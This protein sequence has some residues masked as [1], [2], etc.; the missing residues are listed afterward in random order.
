MGKIG[1]RL[2]R[3]AVLE[4]LFYPHRKHD[5]REAVSNLLVRSDEPAGT[6]QG[7]LCPHAS[8]QY[9]GLHQA[10]SFK[11]A[12]AREISCI[13]ILAAATHYAD[14]TPAIPE[15]HIFRTPLGDSLIDRKSL[16]RVKRSIPRLRIDDLPFLE[17]PAI[18]TPLPFIQFLWPH[19]RIVPIVVPGLA[20][21]EVEL[22]GDGL[23]EALSIVP[24]KHI[25]WIAS[26][27]IACG[28]NASQTRQ[29]AEDVLQL[30][31]SET[32]FDPVPVQNGVSKPR[33]YPAETLCRLLRYCIGPARSCEVLT[34]GSSCDLDGN[35]DSNTEY[36]AVAFGADSHSG[37]L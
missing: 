28:G 12:A 13:V 3:E 37:V 33:T 10:T 36:A 34:R 15:S 32:H 16:T 19:A 17:S 8:L 35:V 6:A 25:L 24:E 5:L 22:L 14:R 23:R 7:I 4:G 2:V 20:L 30:L 11:A 18:E 27:N 1:E 29:D 31:L 26:T 9:A 21:S